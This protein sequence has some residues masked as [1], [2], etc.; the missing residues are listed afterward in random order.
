[1]SYCGYCNIHLLKLLSVVEVG[2]C[3]L[4]K[5]CVVILE[6]VIFP[7]ILKHSYNGKC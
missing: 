4:E 5:H 1:M 7:V 6:E 2:T 3:I